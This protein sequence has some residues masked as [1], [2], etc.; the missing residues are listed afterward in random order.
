M[1][2]LFI[3]TFGIILSTSAGDIY[4]QC[5]HD[6]AFGEEMNVVA[7]THTRQALGVFFTSAHNYLL[8]IV[9]HICYV[10]VEVLNRC[11]S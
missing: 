1:N 7:H 3:W 4:Q 9:S 6:N 2:N 10:I 8:F 5:S 11:A